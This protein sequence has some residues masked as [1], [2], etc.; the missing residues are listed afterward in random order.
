MAIGKYP[1][2]CFT[3]QILPVKTGPAYCCQADG[4]VGLGCGARS[5]TRQLH[6][7]TKYAVSR[8]N[9]RAILE[10]YLKRNE[11]SFLH[12]NHGYCLDIEDQQRRFA[13]LSLLLIEGLSL[14]E[15]YMYFKT[16]ALDEL[17][18]NW[19]PCLRT[20]L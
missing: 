3:P 16:D 15:Y 13:I 12:A 4:M 17:A 18:A 10:D 20:A 6:Y 11:S 5:Y 2:E 19:A 1:Y 8:Q 14:K 7:S 9:I